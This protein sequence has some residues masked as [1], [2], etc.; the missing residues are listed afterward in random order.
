MRSEVVRIRPGDEGYG[1]FVHLDLS[2][3]ERAYCDHICASAFTNIASTMPAK[4]GEITSEL[5]GFGR[6]RLI[7]RKSP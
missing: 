1:G 5:T 7:G 4:S 3:V 2:S 6:D